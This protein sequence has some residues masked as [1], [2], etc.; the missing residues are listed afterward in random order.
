MRTLFLGLIGLCLST[1][2][3]ANPFTFVAL[4]DTAYKLPRDTARVDR[5]IE[6]ING[7]KPAFSIHVGDFKGYSSCSDDALRAVQVQYRKLTTPMVLTPGDN[8]WFDCSVETAGGFDPLDRLSALRRIFFAQPLR[9]GTSPAV[10]QQ[11]YPENVRWT[12][13]GVAFATVHVI[14]PHNGFVRDTRLGAEAIARSNAGENWIREAFASA[15]QAHAPALVLAFQADP[16]ITN[17]PVYENGPLDWLR[18]AIGEE[19]AT[20][21]G[22]VLVVNGDSHRLTID[23]PYRRA[24]IEAG[25]TRGLNITRLMVPGWPDH[26]AVRITVDPAKPAVFSFEVIMAPEESRGAASEAAKP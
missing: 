23:T 1:A 6:A 7:A 11:D 22:Q 26:R 21:D 24:D 16:W 25:T 9:V 3:A 20:F 10:R 15:R 8:D 13:D 2:A 4:G 12:Y 5:L 17:A 19:A 18:N 14:G